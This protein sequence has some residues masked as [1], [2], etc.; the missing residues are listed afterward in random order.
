LSPQKRG[1]KPAADAALAR[2]VAR[3]R[4]ENERLEKRLEQAETI[5]EVRK[6]LSQLLG[7]NPEENESDG[8]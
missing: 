3:L 7:L 6:I 1:P 5:I 2:E 4:R 8:R